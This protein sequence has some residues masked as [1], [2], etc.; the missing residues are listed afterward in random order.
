MLYHNSEEQVKSLIECLARSEINMLVFFIDNSRDKKLEGICTSAPGCKYIKTD[1]N[2][3]YG[4]AHNIATQ[5][6][7]SISKWHLILN[8]DIR[9]DAGCL[10]KLM[11]HIGQNPKLGMIVPRVLYEDGSM[12]YLC[13]LLPTPWNVFSRRFIPFQWLVERGNYLYEMRFSDYLTPMMIP[14]ASGCFMF[15]RS[16]A[17]A[18]IGGF[19]ERFF[20]YAEDVD[21][22]RR[23]HCQYTVQYFPEVSIFH[24][25]NK[26]SYRNYR[27]L[28]YHVVSLIRYFNKWGWFMDPERRRL[29]QLAIRPFS[30]GVA[31]K[32]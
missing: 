7:V 13:K 25:Y 15:C 2:L 4:R 12:Q 26:E 6:C 32:K 31:L 9:F 23:M 5:S 17:L 24:G 10:R 3:G 29:N 1:E 22:S 21:L 20:M 18:K 11:A 27:L 19:D 8:P 16:E 28:K 14:C 30:D